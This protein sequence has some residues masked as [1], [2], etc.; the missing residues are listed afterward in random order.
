MTRVVK[1]KNYIGG[2]Y[3]R[4]SN[5]TEQEKDFAMKI[6]ILRNNLGFSL[7]EAG[8][9]IGISRAALYK[10]ETNETRRIPLDKIEAIAKAYDVTPS[11]LC[12]WSDNKLN[13]KTNNKKFIDNLIDLI[14]SEYPLS[15][16]NNKMLRALISNK[17][18]KNS[19]KKMELKK[20]LEEYE[21][22]KDYIYFLLKKDTEVDNI[23]HLEE[24]LKI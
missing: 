23:P 12:G 22:L 19:K 8:E 14:I 9:K 11:Y 20:W 7:E 21:R 5:P 17:E 10:F 3:M 13:D 2:V 6:K 24:L 4:I 15:R 18:H 16:N 1:L